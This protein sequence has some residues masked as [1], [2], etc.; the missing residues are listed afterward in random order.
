M[1]VFRLLRSNRFVFGNGLR[2]RSVG[3][4]GDSREVARLEPAGRNLP[5]KRSQTVDAGDL[6][7]GRLIEILGQPAS[8]GQP[9]TEST[10]LG[11][12]AVVA[13]VGLLSDMIWS[14]PRLISLLSRFITLQ[15]GDLL[16]TGTPAG[17]GPLVPGD[18]VDAHIDGIGDLSVTIR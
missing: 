2:G 8:S 10:A 9:V 14:V 18:K 7:S 15:P 13:C 12:A 5:E 16:M 11:V 4:S 6:K 3:G 17:V 1:G